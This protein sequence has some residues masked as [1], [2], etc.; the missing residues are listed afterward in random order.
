MRSDMFRFYVIVFISFFLLNN[1][2]IIFGN[3]LFDEATK[4]YNAK[5]Y[6]AAISKY[7]AILAEGLRSSAVYYNL[8]NCYYQKSEQA[9]AMLNYERALQLSPRDKDI[10]FNRDVLQSE[11]T[12]D[13]EA[14]PQF[15]LSRWWETLSSLGS[16]TLWA[17]LALL[18]LWLGIG[19]LASWI[20][21]K[22]RQQKKRGFIGALAF[23]LPFLLAF[24][25]AR[26]SYISE[27]DS[28]A[29][30]IMP[31][32]VTL[33]SAP[34]AI[35][36]EISKLHSGTKVKLLDKIDDWFKVGL[37]NGETGWLPEQEL[38]KI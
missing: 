19:S 35:S 1:N 10:Q 20:I 37:R 34:D 22:T 8:G 15:F 38:E 33:R 32:E 26:S 27:R 25:L 23:T 4:A 7:E 24:F 6:D 13:I 14:I 21:G 18:F 5:Q 12:D 11:L 3:S 17:I 28:K 2:S 16:S 36:K 30:I 29:A 9:K 31:K